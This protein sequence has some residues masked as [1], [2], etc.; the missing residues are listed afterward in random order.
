LTYS[1]MLPPFL[2]RL[3]GR[4][5]ECPDAGTFSGERSGDQETCPMMAERRLLSLQSGFEILCGR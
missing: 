5:H 3:V 4:D 2:S 1:T